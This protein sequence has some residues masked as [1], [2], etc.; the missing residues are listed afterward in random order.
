MLIWATNMSNLVRRL[1]A[2]FLRLGGLFDKDRRDRDLAD[3]ME[4]HLEM[5]IEDNLRRGMTPEQARR[6]ALIKLGGIQPAKET[7]RDR[8]AVFRCSK[9]PYR[10]FAMACARTAR[11]WHSAWWP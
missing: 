5:H 4:S 9:Q 6:Q 1:R 2:A 8:R 7:Y 3:E 10:I 11:T